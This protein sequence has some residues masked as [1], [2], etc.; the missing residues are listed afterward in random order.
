M[1]NRLRTDISEDEEPEKELIVE[2]K[3]PKEFS[4]NY[5]T[6]L[7]NKGAFSTESA[8]RALPGARA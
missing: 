1:S 2:K 7:F 6:Q 8:T 3:A 5:F 4:E